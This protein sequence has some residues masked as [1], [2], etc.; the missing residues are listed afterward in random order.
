MGKLIK[1]EIRKTLAVKLVILGVTAFLEALF[2][3]G[4]YGRKEDMLAV[5]VIFLTLTAFISLTVIGLGSLLTLHRDMNTRQS[6][7]LFMTPHN[8]YQILGAK[9]LENGVS[10]LLTGAFFFALGALDITLLFAREGQLSQIWDMIQSFLTSLDSRLTISFPVMAALTVNLLTSWFSTIMAAYLGDVISSALLNGKK[11]NGLLSFVLILLLVFGIGSL[12][13]A[14]TRDMT[15]FIRSC[16]LDSIIALVCA[17]VMYV[18]TAQI[19]E[20]RL[21]V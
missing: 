21:S 17:A 9:V 19:M 16:N 15:D 14:C 1:Y 10:I 3:I 20:R 12:Q 5:S 7:M 13:R 2:L 11:M 8:A 4:L 6:Y 18:L